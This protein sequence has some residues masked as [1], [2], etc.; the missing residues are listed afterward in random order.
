[1]FIKLKLKPVQ[2]T[3]QPTMSLGST[4]HHGSGGGGV[5][6]SESYTEGVRT[7]LELGATA[8]SDVDSAHST[9]SASCDHGYGTEAAQ[10]HAA[11]TNTTASG[12]EAIA[13]I[14]LT[15]SAAKG[16]LYDAWRRGIVAEL[17]SFPG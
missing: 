6:R 14:N 7:N 13:V 1:M 9:A 8:H 5:L 17:H 2:P 16:G 11:G 10:D 3:T 12:S 4:D 15:I